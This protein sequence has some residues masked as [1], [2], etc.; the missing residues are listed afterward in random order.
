MSRLQYQI[1]SEVSPC[2]DQ[3]ISLVCVQPSKQCMGL[4]LSRHVIMA[5]MEVMFGAP[6][7]ERHCCS[8]RDLHCTLLYHNCQSL[9][10]TALNEH[11]HGRCVCVRSVCVTCTHLVVLQCIKA[12]PRALYY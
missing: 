10:K 11:M 1:R 2:T 3:Q 5:V 7:D 12:L 6:G 9:G 4:T 8:V